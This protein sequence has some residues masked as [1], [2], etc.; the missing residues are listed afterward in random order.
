MIS[1][2]KS[3]SSV[4]DFPIDQIQKRLETWRRS[5]K[6]RS[7][8]PIQLWNGAVRV[9]RQC[10]VNKTAKALHLDYYDLK[11]RLEG[12][13]VD[14]GSAPSF[15]ELSPTTLSAIPECLIE[16]E[17]RNGAKMRIHLKGT[18]VPDLSALSGVFWR[19][20]R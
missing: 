5:H 7:R 10:G 4:I 19:V 1:K 14:R 11:K 6:P 3:Q 8:L 15:I 18:T 12:A 13:A 16:L 2:K 20:K 17:V 9:A